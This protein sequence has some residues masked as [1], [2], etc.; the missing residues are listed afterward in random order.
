MGGGDQTTLHPRRAGNQVDGKM[1]FK[2]SDTRMRFG[3]IDQHFFN[4]LTG[5][6]LG[7]NDPLFRVAAF[8]AQVK[9]DLPP[10]RRFHTMDIKVDTEP[11]E[12]KNSFRPFF[13]DHLHY[14]GIA[15]AIA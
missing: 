13:Y 14:I 2:N 11:A 6:V 12:L 1:V 9:L 7:V 5:H 3:P 10:G 8:L 15:E 4:G